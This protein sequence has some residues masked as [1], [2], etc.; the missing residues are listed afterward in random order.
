MGS[1]RDRIRAFNVSL[2]ATA[3]VGGSPKSES[4]TTA[5]GD[6]SMQRRQTFSRVG[7][8]HTGAAEPAALHAPSQSVTPLATPPPQAAAD[9]SLPMVGTAVDGSS[10]ERRVASQA[11]HD[12]AARAERAARPLSGAPAGASAPANASSAVEQLQRHG[13][14]HFP[15]SGELALGYKGRPRSA[16]AP[17]ANLPPLPGTAAAPSPVGPSAGTLPEP[18][19]SNHG[20]VRS[21]ATGGHPSAA[22][23]AA[24]PGS[25]DVTNAAAGAAGTTANG[26]KPAAQPAALTDG[27]SHAAVSVGR[28][29]AAD[30]LGRSAAAMSM[31]RGSFGKSGS[32]PVKQPGQASL[33]QQQQPQQQQ[34]ISQRETTF[35]R[36][37]DSDAR[38]RSPSHVVRS[39]CGGRGSAVVS[40]QQSV[41]TFAHTLHNTVA[42]QSC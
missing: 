1:V 10:P 13:G 42:G 35:S 32:S 18:L 16:A 33:P 25:V 7:N 37:S 15:L 31:L 40:G 3:T 24:K 5:A 38:P 39:S 21:A 23:A 22:V 30:P 12:A 2:E 8:R 29:R 26:A 4:P 27:G 6:G 28:S 11:A 14:Y 36:L 20:C 19:P 34:P 9:A 17:R 41:L